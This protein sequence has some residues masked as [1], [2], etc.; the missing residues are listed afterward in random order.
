MRRLVILALLLGGMQLVLKA[1]PAEAR[2]QALLTFG[3]LILAAYSVGE[4][5]KQFRLPK[6]VGYL[7]A[8]AVF[9]PDA[10][11]VVPQ[12]SV[13]QLGSVSNLAIVEKEATSKTDLRIGST[14][15]D[16]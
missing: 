2:G 12:A 10:L 5:A 1:G 9:G 13:E 16:R 8:G 15:K 14:P 7:A 3:F 6:I 4:L 11:A